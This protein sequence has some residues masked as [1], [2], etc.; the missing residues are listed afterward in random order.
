MTSPAKVV[1]FVIG[2]ILAIAFVVYGSFALYEGSWS[3]ASHNLTHSLQL[4][5]QR[6][7]G[8][9]QNTVSGWNY[10]TMLGQEITQ[11]IDNVTQDTSNID[12]A[13]LQGLTSYVND[14]K[15]Q[16]QAD[17]NEVCQE[18]TQVNGS[19]PVNQPQTQ[20]VDK[21][22]SAGSVSPSSVFYYTGN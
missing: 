4:Q 14:L 2:C 13:Q 21:N 19:L 22:C 7:N 9:A 18:A 5:K 15:S 11:H 12:N 20:W 3:L 16:R 8:E 6:A 17:A 10:Q 1:A